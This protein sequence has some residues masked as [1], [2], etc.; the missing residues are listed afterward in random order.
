M[1]AHFKRT[2]EAPTRHKVQNCSFESF[3]GP[4]GIFFPYTGKRFKAECCSFEKFVENS[5]SILARDS[6]PEITLLRAVWDPTGNAFAYKGKRSKAE[7]WGQFLA[8]FIRNP[9]IHQC[10]RR[11]QFWPVL[12]GS[13]QRWSTFLIKGQILTTFWKF[14]GFCRKLKV[15]QNLTKLNRNQ[16]EAWRPPE[17]VQKQ[18]SDYR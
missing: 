8:Y 3:V 11:C 9:S 18:K 7:K 4:T 5:S 17:G 6:R 13:G 15:E 16:N 2:K 14:V 10:S 1:S 12:A